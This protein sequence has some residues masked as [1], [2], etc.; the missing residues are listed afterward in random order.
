[1]AL[2]I[3]TWLL[4]F[5]LFYLLATS[6]IFIRNRFEL[7][8]LSASSESD[9]EPNV[10]VCIPARNEEK[11]VGNLLASLENQTWPNYNVHVLDEQSTDRTFE[12]ADS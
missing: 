11:T 10:S 8:P 6:L 2:Q 1:M 3:I 7:T 12:I 5:A 4:F 9:E